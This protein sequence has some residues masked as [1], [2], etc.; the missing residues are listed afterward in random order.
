MVPAR[1]QGQRIKS[2]FKSWQQGSLHGLGKSPDQASEPSPNTSDHAD[3]ETGGTSRGKSG[4]HHQLRKSSVST[5][6]HRNTNPV[7]WI[8]IRKWG[9]AQDKMTW[10]LHK[11]LGADPTLQT[12]VVTSQEVSVLTLLLTATTYQCSFTTQRKRLRPAPH[13]NPVAHSYRERSSTVQL[14]FSSNAKTGVVTASCPR[15]VY[16]GLNLLVD[17]LVDRASE[18][19]AIVSVSIT[20]VEVIS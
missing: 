1:L 7:P 16:W 13:P 11:A 3:Q 18:F 14:V 4:A 10:E 9:K 6:S 8:Q 5:N 15:K 2:G 17:L 19:S 20:Q 12:H